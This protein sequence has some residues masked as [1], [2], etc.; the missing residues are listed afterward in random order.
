MRARPN[1]GCG[2]KTVGVQDAEDRNDRHRSGYACRR[3]GSVTS[4]E[5]FNKSCETRTGTAAIAAALGGPDDYRKH[6]EPLSLPWRPPWDFLGVLIEHK[7]FEHERL[8][9]LCDH[10]RCCGAGLGR[11]TARKSCSGGRRRLALMACLPRSM[12]VDNDNVP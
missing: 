3:V 10:H 7:R 8:H 12:L 5:L 1:L 9:V 11:R 2:G 6:A 4:G